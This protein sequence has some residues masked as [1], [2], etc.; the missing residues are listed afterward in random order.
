VIEDV[1][2]GLD[3]YELLSMDF[4]DDVDGDFMVS[5]L[6]PKMRQIL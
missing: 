6:V 5:V 2:R 3:V 1:L 4:R